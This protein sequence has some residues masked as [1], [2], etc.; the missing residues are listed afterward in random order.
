MIKTRGYKRKTNLGNYESADFWAEGETWEEVLADVKEQIDK[1]Q[2]ET[3][4]DKIKATMKTFD[5]ADE[6]LP[7]KVGRFMIEL[8]T[9]YNK[10]YENK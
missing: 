4:L 10:K 6:K 3:L 9:P 8:L 2:G 5:P 7:Q 1:Y